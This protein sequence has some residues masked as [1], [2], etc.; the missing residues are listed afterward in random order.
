MRISPLIIVPFLLLVVGSGV[1]GD[2]ERFLV[3]TDWLAAH[4]DDQDLVVVHVGT[5]EDTLAEIGQT[6]FDRGHIP[7][8]RPLDWSEIAVT[9]EGLPNE[10]P[11]A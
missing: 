4:L 10:Y 1:P 3:G 6:G 11:T 2:R 8:A 5:P 7:F 9:R